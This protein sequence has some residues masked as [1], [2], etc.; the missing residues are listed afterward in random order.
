MEKVYDVA[1][2]F[3]VLD[4]LEYFFLFL[5]VHLTDNFNGVV[6]I[7]VVD[8]TLGD[9]FGGELL[10]QLI[11]HVLVHL[12]EGICSFLVVK[13]AVEE[14]CFLNVEFKAELCD[15]GRVHS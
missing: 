9:G 13:L 8:E 5:L 3:N 1:G 15:V 6:C 10:E 11:T 7:H 12:G 2:L 14:T 4:V